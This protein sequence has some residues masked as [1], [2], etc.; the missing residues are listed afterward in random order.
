MGR[1]PTC[2]LAVIL[3]VAVIRRVAV[4]LGEAKDL[5][6]HFGDELMQ[7]LRCAQNDGL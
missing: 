2:K 7:I 3:R 5:H 1:W 4:I 6:L